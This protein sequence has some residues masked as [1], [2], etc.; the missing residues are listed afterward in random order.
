MTV[1]ADT[2][3]II[4]A[5]VDEVASDVAEAWLASLK[6]QELVSSPWCLTESASA[7][8]GK[9]RAGALTS[10]SRRRAFA[11]IRA[12]L[13]GVAIGLVE[14]RHFEQAA[15]LLSRS[16]RPLSAADALHLAIASDVGATLWTL[17]RRMAEAGQALG[18]DVEHLR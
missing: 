2:S 17:D 12:L 4:S 8:A 3:I 10:Q 1:Y 11:A 6:P 5:Y 16:K 14:N 7:L 15:D 9:V 18:L 13:L